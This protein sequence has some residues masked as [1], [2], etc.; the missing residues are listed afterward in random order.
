M[1]VVNYDCE[2][3]F[4]DYEMI[5]KFIHNFLFWCKFNKFISFFSKKTWKSFIFP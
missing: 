1:S 5:Y 3:Y 2:L 4:A